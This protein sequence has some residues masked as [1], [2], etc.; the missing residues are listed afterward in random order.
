MLTRKGR[1]IGTA[2]M[3]LLSALLWEMKEGRRKKEYAMWAP[4]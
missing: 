2:S 1:Q 4:L 3:D